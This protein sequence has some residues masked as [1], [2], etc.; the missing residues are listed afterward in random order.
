MK[1]VTLTPEQ[2]RSF[3]KKGIEDDQSSYLLELYY[4]VIGKE[5]FQSLKSVGH[6]PKCN[7]TTSSFIFDCI[8]EYAPENRKL[9]MK[10]M[11]VNKGFSL[12]NDLPD[13]T[14]AYKPEDLIFGRKEK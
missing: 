8:D 10:F 2:I 3:V 13:Y 1:K 9:S 4:A 6:F 12:N 5:T 11:Y 14:I 7:E